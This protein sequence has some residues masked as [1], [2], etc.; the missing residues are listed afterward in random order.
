MKKLSRV[1]VTVLAVALLLAIPGCSPSDGKTHLTFQIW[2]VAQRESMEAICAAYTEQN[3]DVVIEVQVTGWTEYWTKLEAAAESNTMPDIFWMHTNQILYYSDFGILADV[4]DL[5]DDVEPNYY[6]NHFSEISIG[7][8]SGSDGRLYGVPK[9]KDNIILVYNKEMF[10]AAG[11]SYP[12]DEWTWDDL[13]AASEKIYDTT[14]KYG[15]MAYNEDHLGYWNFVYQAG[16][17]ILNED[18]TK[19]GFTQPATARAIEFYVGMQQND[20]CPDQTYFAETQPGIAFFSEV[21]SMYLEGNWELMNK[22]T[23][24]P[25]MEGK[26]DIAKLPKCPDP[27]SGDGRATISNG[28]CYATAAR[29]KNLETVKDVLKFF[30]TEEAQNIASSYGAAISAYNGT[31]IPYFEAF[32]KKGYDLNLQVIEDQFEYSIQCVNNAARP[33]WKSPV[34]DEL[35]KA[36]NGSS[37][38]STVL[39]NMQRIV[40]DATAASL[41]R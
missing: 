1:F 15:F 30:G 40:D 18:K 28:L 4:T 25:N 8:A 20:W 37:D 13:I 27:E 36:Y 24:Y 41:S 5:Y 14:G 10:D 29:G 6:Q 32:E 17:Y 19:A 38:L 39:A 12:D 11:L 31:E 34:L 2:D 21:G 33:K 7:N 26:W 23:S 35:N 16:G 9:D 22:S 3:P